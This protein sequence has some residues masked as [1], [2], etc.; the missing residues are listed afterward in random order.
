M[1]SHPLLQKAISFPLPYPVFEQIRSHLE[2]HEVTYSKS[3]SPRPTGP[4]KII[5][6]ASH[7]YPSIAGK[8]QS[9]RKQ[10]AIKRYVDRSPKGV[11]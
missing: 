8:R 5:R 4:F 3:S 10:F 9:L 11:G 7:S 1:A 6:D 2:M